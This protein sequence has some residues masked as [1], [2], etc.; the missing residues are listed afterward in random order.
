MSTPQSEPS[1]FG[2][3][4][5]QA[6]DL[7]IKQITGTGAAIG[8]VTLTRVPGAAHN[9]KQKFVISGLTGET[10]T[11]KGWLVG[12]GATLTAALSPID[13]S[14]GLP[15]A[16][17]NLGNGTYIIP[18]RWKFFGFTFTKSNTV[19][20]GVISFASATFPKV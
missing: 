6:I 16:S 9:V 14:T 13:D 19:E 7:Q 5:S 3:R 2:R 4:A 20:T 10:I 18:A 12:G 17:S 8:T 1:V 15:V 11:I